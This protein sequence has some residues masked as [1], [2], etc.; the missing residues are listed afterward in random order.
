MRSTLPFKRSE[1]KRRIGYAASTIQNHGDVGDGESNFISS[2]HRKLL[3]IDWAIFCPSW[4]EIESGKEK[5][6]ARHNLLVH[7]ADIVP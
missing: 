7:R 4:L 6:N 3:E 2:L 5:K 1:A